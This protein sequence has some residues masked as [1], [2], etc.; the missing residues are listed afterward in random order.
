MLTYVIN[1][2]ENKAFDSSTLFELTGYNKEYKY[3]QNMLFPRMYSNDHAHLYE[4]WVGKPITN[5]VRAENYAYT[6]KPYVKM[7]TQW[8]NM[9]FFFN[10]QVNNMY[11][12]Y[13]LW[14]FVGRQNDIQNRGEIEYGNWITGIPFVDKLLVGDQKNIPADM[15]EKKQLS[16][17]DKS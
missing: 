5:M 15:K 11:W 1:T 17:R 6:G 12:R 13:F 3:V 7:P 9:R 16:Q 10:Y 14:N 2:S 4:K 8:D